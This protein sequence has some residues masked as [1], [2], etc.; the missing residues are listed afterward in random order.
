MPVK[1]IRQTYDELKDEPW[2]LSLD[3]QRNPPK[4]EPPKP[5]DTGARPPSGSKQK[6]QE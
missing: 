4:A 2:T 6:T 3:V 5:A 1:V